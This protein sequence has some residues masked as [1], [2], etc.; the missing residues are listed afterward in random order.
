[1]GGRGVLGH[2][3]TYFVGDDDKIPVVSAMLGKDKE[4]S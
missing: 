4:Y 3:S 2:D 1:V